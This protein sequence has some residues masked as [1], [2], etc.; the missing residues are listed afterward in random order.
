PTL[1]E[2]TVGAGRGRV[3][4]HVGQVVLAIAP[5]RGTGY[6]INVAVI[7]R[8][9]RSASRRRGRR[10]G[11]RSGRVKPVVAR[12]AIVLV[13]SRLVPFVFSRND[14][15]ST[16]LSRD[17]VQ[18]CISGRTIQ[19]I[20]TVFGG[21]QGLATGWLAVLQPVGEPGRIAPV[22]IGDW[23]TRRTNH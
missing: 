9:V 15:S 3:R 19:E 20:C 8:R 16:G 6:G 11:V 17:R 13:I 10:R 4:A 22:N 18:R 21:A 12:R 1:V 5:T 7:I 23:I 14:P 2:R